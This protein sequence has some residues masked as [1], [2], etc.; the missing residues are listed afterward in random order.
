[1]FAPRLGEHQVRLY[2]LG[3]GI[4][5]EKNPRVSSRRLTMVA[6]RKRDE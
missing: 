2:R 5:N 4:G 6:R 3:L 1:V